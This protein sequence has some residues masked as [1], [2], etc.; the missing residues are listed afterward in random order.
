DIFNYVYDNGY[1]RLITGSWML[2]RIQMTG[3]LRDYFLYMCTFI[4]LIIGYTTFSYFAFAINTENVSAIDLYM[5]IL[6]ILLFASVVAVPFIN[7]RMTAIIIAGVV[8]FLV[9]LMFTIFRAPDLALTQLLVETV[10]VIL[11]MLVFYHLPK[12][13]K[14][15]MKPSF[16]LINLIV[17]IAV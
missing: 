3:M 8:G 1:N 14:E 9:A 13:R 12:L 10:S 17:S 5:F 4:V 16:K 2:T 7:S 6:A 15:K 11:F